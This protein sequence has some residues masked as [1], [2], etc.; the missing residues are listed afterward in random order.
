MCTLG[1]EQ[2]LDLVLHSTVD[3]LKQSLP[4]LLLFDVFG[5]HSSATHISGPSEYNLEFGKAVS[6]SLMPLL[7]LL[8]LLVT[9]THTE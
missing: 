1:H 8:S 7:S 3:F 2:I 4:V 9:H 6:S 5:K